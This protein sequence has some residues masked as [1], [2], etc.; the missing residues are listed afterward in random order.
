MHWGLTNRPPNTWTHAQSKVKAER[1][2]MSLQ[3][4]S[5][6]AIRGWADHP[7]IGSAPTCKETQMEPTPTIGWKLTQVEGWMSLSHGSKGPPFAWITSNR[8]G[9]AL[10]EQ[11]H[12]VHHTMAVDPTLGDKIPCRP[13]SLFGRSDRIKLTVTPTDIVRRNIGRLI[14]SRWI[15]RLAGLRE[16]DRPDFFIPRAHPSRGR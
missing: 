5:E 16:A 8:R 3:W 1:P 15:K 12:I 14:K 2:H 7:R 11:H 4:A 13:A 6:V 10:E 9:I